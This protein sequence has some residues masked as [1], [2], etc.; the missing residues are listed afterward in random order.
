MVKQTNIENASIV[1]F[2][3][4]FLLFVILTPDFVSLP[5][6][7]KFKQMKESIFNIFDFDGSAKDN[8]RNTNM[9]I[10]DLHCY[11]SQKYVETECFCFTWYLFYRVFWPITL[12]E[13]TFVQELPKKRIHKIIFICCTHMY[14]ICHLTF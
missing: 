2:S 8:Q 13:H 4:A 12:S 11:S 1:I 7:P 10:L 5:Y 9:Y 14:C 6:P 3:C